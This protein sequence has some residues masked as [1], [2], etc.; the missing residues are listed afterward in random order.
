MSFVRFIAANITG[1]RK[2][3]IICVQDRGEYD[4]LIKYM[5]DSGISYVLI[6]ADEAAKYL[7]ADDCVGC[8]CYT[9]Y[10]CLPN[11]HYYRKALAKS[12]KQDIAA[13]IGWIIMK[14]P[15]EVFI[16]SKE[17]AVDSLAERIVSPFAPIHKLAP[18]LY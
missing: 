17:T 18:L 12:R 14:D 3:D 9:L 6:E 7:T 4:S 15:V 11:E 10:G 16:R 5:K 1:Q 13:Y 2:L 8:G